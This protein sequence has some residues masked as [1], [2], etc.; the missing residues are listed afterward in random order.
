MCYE[1]NYCVLG[2]ALRLHPF[3]PQFRLT[4]QFSVFGPKSQVIIAGPCDLKKYEKFFFKIFAGYS[5][6]CRSD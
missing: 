3:N 4:P 1:L 2:P 5:T 6:Q